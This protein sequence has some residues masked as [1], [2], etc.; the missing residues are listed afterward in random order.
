MSTFHNEWSN[1]STTVYTDGEEQE[2]GRELS[3]IELL[4]AAVIKQAI[5]D[6]S[7]KHKLVGERKE[8][9]EWLKEEQFKELCVILNL[10]R[11][12]VLKCAHLEH[13]I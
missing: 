13:L 9:E 10:D 5:D 1:E 4:W 12:Y 3:E 8:A 7:P 2:N 6:A 11:A